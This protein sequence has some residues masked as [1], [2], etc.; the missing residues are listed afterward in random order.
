MPRG[1]WIGPVL[2]TTCEQAHGA[3]RLD[4]CSGHTVEDD[5]S[6]RLYGG[7]TLRVRGPHSLVLGVRDRRMPPYWM[8]SAHGAWRHFVWVLR[9]RPTSPP[10]CL[11]ADASE[12]R[13]GDPA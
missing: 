13:P 8:L 6:K 2:L 9:G 10:T 1:Y 11:G 12:P 3:P 7:L 4:G 5:G